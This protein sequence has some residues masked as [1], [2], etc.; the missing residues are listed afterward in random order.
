[1]PRRWRQWL[2]P[3]K[4]SGRINKEEGRHGEM[5]AFFMG[6][7]GDGMKKGYLLGKKGQMMGIS[8]KDTT[9]HTRQRPMPALT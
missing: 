8:I 4:K 6:K 9:K 1:M 3:T 5:P 2:R 7:K